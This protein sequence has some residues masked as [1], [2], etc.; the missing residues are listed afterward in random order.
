[1]SRSAGWLLG[2]VA[3]LAIMFFGLADRDGWQKDDPSQFDLSISG[4]TAT[5]PN[6]ISQAA[7]SESQN[8]PRGSEAKQAVSAIQESIQN[9]GGDLHPDDLMVDFDSSIRNAGYNLDPYAPPA[10]IDRPV[11]NVGTNLDPEAPMQ[12]ADA[13]VRNVGD[14]SL[15]IDDAFIA[16]PVGVVIPGV[17][18]TGDPTKTPEE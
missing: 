1:M 12:W 11:Q 14:P 18:N 7:Y 10:A 4:Q 8:Q 9:R 17:I 5:V 6:R 16:D 2:S 3:F 13:E 15:Q